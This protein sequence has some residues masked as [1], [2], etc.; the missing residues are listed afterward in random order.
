[1]PI[2]GDI[3]VKPQAFAAAVAWAVKWIAGRPAAPIAAGVAL[4]VADGTLSLTTYNETVTARATVAIEGLSTGT[5][6]A[7]V[8]GRLLADL[9]ATFKAGKPVNI[10]T[11]EN[12]HVVLTVGRWTGTLPTFLESDWPSLPAEVA[13]V[14]TVAGD[15]FATAVGRVGVAVA[16]DDTKG[17]VFTLMYVGFENGT[18]SLYATDRYRVAKTVLPWTAAGEISTSATPYGS[19]LID[20]AGSFA[21][22]DAVTIGLDG[23]AMSLTTAT[24][25]LTMRLGDPGENGWPAEV[26]DNNIALADAYD[27]LAVLTP[28]EVV[29][30]LKRASIVRGKAGPVKLAFSEGT[31][32]IASSEGQLEQDGNEE[33]DVPY[34]GKPGSMAFDPTYLVTAL[35][36]VPGD[37]V[38]MR[39]QVAEFTRR[40][41]VLSA[42]GDPHWRHVIVPQVVLS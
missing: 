38:E 28:A 21:G 13:A 7:I 11:G 12:G 20:A 40:P 39:F 5:G 10:S 3:S 23:S 8:S 36:S 9:A 26:M 31:L 32:T 17:R 29:L 34:D 14:G 42:A 2:T 1:M 41:V 27:G 25:S 18:L 30:P 16:N 19:M 33:V 15:A 37:T 6:R 22:P 4:D 24:R 35:A